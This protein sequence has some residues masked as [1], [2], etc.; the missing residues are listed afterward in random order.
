MGNTSS[1]A[2]KTPETGFQNFYEILDYI[3]TYYILTMD[4][5]S[6]NKLSEKEY[7]NKLV[8]LSSDIIKK[9]FTELEVTYL[10]QRIKNGLEVNDLSK[11]SIIFLNKDNI[12]NLDV[13]ND[14]QK[15]IRKKRMCI[16][17]AKFYVKIAHIFAAIIMT[18]N[19]V[20][21]YKDASGNIMK[22][23]LLDKDKIPKNTPRKIYKLNI[24]DNRIHAL[25]RGEDYNND[26]LKVHPKVCNINLN[27]EG[28]SK[29]LAD[30][31]GINELSELY[32]DKYDYSTGNFTGMTEPTKKQF[33]QDL[34]TFYTAF[35]GNDVMP[36]EITK[37][38]DI[39]LRT[40]KDN[41]NCQ[42]EKPVFKQTY[43]GNK[44]NKTFNNYAKSIKNMIETAANKQS[45][46]LNVINDLFTFVI[47]PY[48]NKKRIRIN[49]KLNEV[50][51][52]KAV[53][54]SRK[55][56]IEL[57]VNCE[58]D[59]V[60][61]IKLYEAI[62][63]TKILE[64]TQNQIKNL[65]KEATNIIAETNKITNPVES[66]DGYTRQNQ[67]IQSNYDGFETTALG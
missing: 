32:M 60:N 55:I 31:P 42:G 41:K 11:D 23:K 4:F 19:P 7:C 53:E 40:Y 46:L 10:A 16:G 39:K 51:L 8:I 58:T 35:T 62:V 48:T 57:Y 64:T 61:S 44:N 26:I 54:K 38:S 47:D 66:D 5:K 56:I 24:C 59:Y 12:D 30:E 20:Y 3:A 63:E 43:V 13:Q 50:I 29:S 17:I 45:E 6:L 9:Y 52:Q 15:S 25:K 65:E 28:Q 1:N 14:T 34:K 2:N 27:K 36:P 67:N 22:T 33:F 49:P 21:M 37:F 18:I